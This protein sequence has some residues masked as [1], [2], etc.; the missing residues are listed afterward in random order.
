MRIISFRARSEGARPQ[1]LEVAGHPIPILVQRYAK[2]KGYKLR[3]DPAQ[4]RLRLSMPARGRIRPALEWVES[5]REW[6]IA[7]MNAAPM[8]VRLIPGAM[9]PV[10]GVEREIVWR[11]DLPRAPVIEDACILLGGMETAVGARLIRWLK[12]RALE[13]LRAETYDMAEGAGLSIASV[14]IGDPRSRWGSCAASGAIRYSWRL[15]L[16]PPEVRRAIVAHEVA[17]RLHMDHSPAFH[18]AHREI[19]GDDPA[20]ARRWLR[21]HGAAL[22][23]FTA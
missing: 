9:L 17:H 16:V 2:A 5:Q 20:P 10:E 21:E 8:G 18:A 7:Q 1:T 22:H 12:V 13:I 15:I 4:M 6:V 11:H 23:R 14:S 3:Y 19:F